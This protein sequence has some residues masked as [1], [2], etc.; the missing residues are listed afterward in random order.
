MNLNN[1]SQARTKADSE[2]KA[3]DTSVRQHRS[4]PHFVRS[5]LSTDKEDKIKAIADI[6]KQQALLLKKYLVIAKM[7]SP[8]RWQTSVVRV[9]KIFNLTMQAKQLEVQKRIILSQ[10]I[11]K[12][13]KGGFVS[14]YASVG[15][16]CEE[17][18]FKPKSVSVR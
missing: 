4:K 8:K 16:P 18:I 11:P 2:Q 12:F 15:T 13:P 14:G 5:P 10:P 3:E 7:K 6:N 1:K 9:F 17:I